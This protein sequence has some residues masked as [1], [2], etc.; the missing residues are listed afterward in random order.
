[1]GSTAQ[2]HSTCSTNLYGTSTS[3]HHL[4][5]H[6]PHSTHPSS[7]GYTPTPLYTPSNHST[8]HQPHSTHPPTTRLHTNPTLHTLQPLD[9]TPTPLYTPS[10]HSTTHQPHSTHPPTTQLHNPHITLH[11]SSSLPV[12]M[13]LK[14][15]G[16]CHNL[17]QA[18][19]SLVHVP[20]E[21][22]VGLQTH[23]QTDTGQTGL[24]LSQHGAG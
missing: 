16:C 9:Y 6:Q 7:P 3:S 13:V 4:A 11:C 21:E 24:E 19:N 1:M 23:I 18:V 15:H 20:R 10:N 12:L 2:H 17:W 5:T 8:T 14:V 22:T